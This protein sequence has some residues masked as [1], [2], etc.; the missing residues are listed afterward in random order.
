MS[1]REVRSE[2]LGAVKDREAGGENSGDEKRRSVTRKAGGRGGKGR[3]PT[4]NEITDGGGAEACE[5][6]ACALL[7][8]NLAKAPDHAL[9]VN[10]RLKLDAGLDHIHGAHGTVGDGAADAAR[11]SALQVVVETVGLGGGGERGFLLGAESHGT[12]LAGTARRRETA[13]AGTGRAGAISWELEQAPRRAFN[14][15][16]PSYL[17]VRSLAKNVDL[18]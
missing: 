17:S 13:G 2:R 5:K 10:L 4:L 14:A 11:K 18:G 9:V 3:G 7:L 8:D 6:S 16:A 12:S 1:E 15:G